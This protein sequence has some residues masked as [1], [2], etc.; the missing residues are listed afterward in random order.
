MS[1]Q[2]LFGNNTSYNENIRAYYVAPKEEYLFQEE[3]KASNYTASILDLKK[4]YLDRTVK[5]KRDLINSNSSETLPSYFQQD[6]QL[7]KGKDG[8]SDAYTKRGKDMEMMEYFERQTTQ[9]Q[10]WR[11]ETSNTYI[12]FK[13]G[14]KVFIGDDEYVIMLVINQLGIGNVPNFLSVRNNPKSLNRWGVK[15][16]ILV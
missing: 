6:R 11:F 16:L 5:S 9:E 7:F 12:D 10:A 3:I 1:F 13:S 8:T 4:G 15:T 2:N 14:G